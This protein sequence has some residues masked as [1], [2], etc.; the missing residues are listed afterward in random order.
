M[1]DTE[2][3]STLHQASSLLFGAS[4]NGRFLEQTVAASG[5]WK[6][7]TLL[8]GQIA[9]ARVADDILTIACAK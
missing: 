1:L 2:K 8:P 3:V 6:E 9:I 7:S 5:F 4:V